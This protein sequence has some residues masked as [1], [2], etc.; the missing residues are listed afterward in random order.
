MKITSFLSSSATARHHSF[1]LYHQLQTWKSNCLPHQDWEWNIDNKNKCEYRKLG[2][3]CTSMLR[4]WVGR[5]YANKPIINCAYE[6]KNVDKIMIKKKLN[7]FQ[8]GQRAYTQ[9]LTLGDIS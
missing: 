6:D 8:K 2:L 9:T 3:Q 1:Q 5:L 4:E 7:W